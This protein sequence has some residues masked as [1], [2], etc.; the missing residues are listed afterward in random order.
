MTAPGPTIDAEKYEKS[1]TLLLDAGAD[2]LFSDLQLPTN[3]EAEKKL[4]N[5]DRKA[6]GSFGQSDFYS[7]RQFYGLRQ[8]WW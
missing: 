2:F 1:G 5:F 7:H 4:P 6:D 3:E 8:T